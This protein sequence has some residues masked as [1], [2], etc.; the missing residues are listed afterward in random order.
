VSSSSTTSQ[1]AAT[2][3]AASKPV[4]DYY[5][6]FGVRSRPPRRR[7][8]GQV[9]TVVVLIAALLLS[10]VTRYLAM[11]FQDTHSP[12]GSRTIASRSS[13]AGMDTYALALLLGGLRGPLV[14]VLWAQ[15]EAQKADRDLE[16][17]NTQIEW[18]RRLQ[19]E[20]DTVHVFQMWNKAYN[21]SVQ[22][23]GLSNKYTTILDA[24]DYGWSIDAERPDNL[25]IL[26]ELARVYGDKLGGSNPEKHY[27][28]ERLRKETK[29]REPTAGNSGAQRGDPG[30]QRLRHEPL[31]DPSGNILPKYLQPR[32]SIG[33]YD[34]SALQ[35]LKQYEPFPYG[36]SPLAMG[37]NFHKRAQ[38]LMEFAGQ[39][40][41]QV[42]D[43]VVDAQPALALKLWAEEEWERARRMETKAFG[44][45]ISY[46]RLDLELP[47]AAKPV[48]GGFKDASDVAEMIYCYNIM[49]RLVDDST[50]EY[51]RHL[52]NP[53]FVGKR[54][55][56]ASHLD[57]LQGMHGMAIGDRDYLKAIQAP[58]GS[59]ERAALLESSARGY[60][61][62]IRD[63]GLTCLRYFTSDPLAAA[64]MPQG[65]NRSNIGTGPIGSKTSVTDED[66]LR[67]MAGIRKI[68]DAPNAVDEN[69]E[70]RKEY[71]T[72]ITRA[73]ERLRQI[74][75]AGK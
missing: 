42:S 16:G 71:E 22:M 65:V 10:G 26:K 35:F 58:K 20:F 3:T 25:N 6:G 59:P 70:D 62:S 74:Q 69:L 46:E 54:S 28:R 52:A 57:Q 17:I 1:S 61:D 49:V 9:G 68:L 5:D 29:W 34:G 4:S 38:L 31:L 7:T 37:Y 63:F 18:I 75:Q 64:V 24:A 72:Y 15:S 36:V 45:K 41:T 67:M 27:F 11:H 33:P 44:E 53:E 48:D 13:L 30:F 12:R 14:M 47:T 56:Y 51:E 55:L 50:K 32:V 66:V 21:L 19:P 40:P 43:S 73:T 2:T 8:A 39:R 60:R 23:V